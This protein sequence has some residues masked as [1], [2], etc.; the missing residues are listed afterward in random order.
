[1]PANN[2]KRGMRA[3]T[4]KAKSSKPKA[5]APKKVKPKKDPMKK[6]TKVA[7]GSGANMAKK[8]RSG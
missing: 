3:K 1:M 6:T 5:S 2:P 8:K 7:F 4:N